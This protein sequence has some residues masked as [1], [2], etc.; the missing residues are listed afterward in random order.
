ML[1]RAQKWKNRE[2][3]LLDHE[4]WSSDGVICFSAS[5]AV[6]KTDFSDELWKISVD[7]RFS[8]KEN[9]NEKRLISCQAVK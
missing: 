9:I 2:K 7:G 1:K 3:G 6:Q 8:N 4:K 5:H